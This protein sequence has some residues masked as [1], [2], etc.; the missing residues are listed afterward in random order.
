MKCMA[1]R[2]RENLRE[3]G[4]QDAR[5]ICR[6]LGINSRRCIT[7]AGEMAEF[8]NDGALLRHYQQQPE[9]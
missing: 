7:G 3:N 4:T 1:E 2:R 6:N 8:V 5:G 9:A